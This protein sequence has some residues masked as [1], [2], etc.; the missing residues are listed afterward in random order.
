MGIKTLLA[1]LLLI[2]SLSVF[3]QSSFETSFNNGKTLFNNGKYELA[4][5]AFKPA[6]VASGANAYEAYAS[7]YY[8]ISAYRSNYKPMA[9][10]MFLQ[11][12]RNFPDWEFKNES[13]Y[14]VTLIRFETNQLNQALSSAAELDNTPVQNQSEALQR[15]YLLEIDSIALLK[16]L[17][18]GNQTNRVLAKVIVEK[19]EVVSYEYVDFELLN[20]VAT[21]HQLSISAHSVPTQVL[22]KDVYKVAVL[23]PFIWQNMEVSGFYLRKSLVVDLYEGIRLGLDKLKEQGINID[24]I[25]YDTKGDTLVTSELLTKPEMLGVDLIIGPLVPGPS[26]LVR[27]FAYHNK[28]NMVNPVSSNSSAVGG[29]PYAF[30]MNPNEYTLGEKAGMFATRNVSNKNALVYYGT[31]GTDKNMAMAYKEVIE[32][33]SFNI[34]GMNRVHHDSTERI[35]EYLTAKQY[36]RDSLGN[37]V[38]YKDGE[39][40]KKLEEYII[41][42]DSIGSIFVSTLDYKVAAEVFS[43]VADR[44]DSVNI[45]I[46]GHGTWLQDRTANYLFMQELGIVMMSPDYVN[47]KSEGYL[48]LEG[49]YISSQHILPSKFVIAGYDCML[50][51]GYCLNNFGV[52]FQSGLRES[53]IKNAGLRRGYDYRT[54]NDNRYIPLLQFKNLDIKVDEDY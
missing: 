53:V 42:P 25:A 47:Y 7:F 22:K 41:N 32:A 11:I 36:V 46:I 52:Y 17:Y 45:K 33:D 43:S 50:F 21:D 3:A 39:D 28:I 27:D 26:A 29:N 20:R 1:C 2:S 13:L 24:L 49:N 40:T 10:D 54:S 51:M 8:A 18:E 16:Q 19:M 4:M 5:Q 15:K 35:F 34:I 23:F 30:L 44:G 48:E 9:R 14:W 38:Y 37:V 12:I 31:R 6:M